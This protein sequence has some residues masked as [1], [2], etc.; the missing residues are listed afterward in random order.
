MT[1]ETERKI[2]EFWFRDTLWKVV[3]TKD[4]KLEIEFERL[5]KR[6]QKKANKEK[7][8]K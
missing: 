3:L 4:G 2:H 6:K 5:G 1:F 7:L 8:W